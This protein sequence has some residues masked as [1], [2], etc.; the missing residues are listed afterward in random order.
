[1]LNANLSW[2]Y[3][4]IVRNST[5]NTFLKLNCFVL[6]VIAYRWDVFLENGSTVE[7][8]TAPEATS[9]GTA[10][11]IPEHVGCNGDG[12]KS[13]SFLGFCLISFLVCKCYSFLN[14]W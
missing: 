9:L 10:G 2:I 8:I 12:G 13:M 7:K 1:M 3:A 14:S 5:L 4:K 6:L 11:R